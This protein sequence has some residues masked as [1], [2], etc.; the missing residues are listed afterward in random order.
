MNEFKMCPMC[1]ARSIQYVQGKKWLC[2]EC[3][4]DLYNNVA[5]AV[6]LIIVLHDGRILFERRAKEPRKNFLA[7]PG[8]FVDPDESAENAALRECKEE[9]GVMPD[10]IKYLCSFPN[11]Y[12]YKNITYKTCDIFFTAR[13]S[14][15]Q[16]VPQQGEVL[17]FEPH[18]VRDE[19]EL[20]D[21]PLAFE[22]ARKTLYLWLKEKI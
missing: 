15:E 4:F 7:F 19:K 21:L 13:I 18:F 16:F 3:G 17:S 20:A 2:P 10:E 5:S 12:E 14:D 6:G 22:S 11:T 9:I 8:G 1:G